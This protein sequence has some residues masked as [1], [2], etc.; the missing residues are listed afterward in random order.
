VPPAKAEIHVP[1]CTLAGSHRRLPQLTQLLPEA[2]VSAVLERR[3]RAGVGWFA[4]G[5]STLLACF[6]AFW[7]SN[8]AFHEGWFSPSFW[9]NVA[10]TLV[11]YMAPMLV[12]VIPTA[13]CTKWRAVGVVFYLG[14]AGFLFFFFHHSVRTAIP[15]VFLAICFAYGTPRPRRLAFGLAVGLPLL[16]AIVCGAGP[17][18]RVAHR[19]N[20]GNYGMRRI[21]GNGV[22]LTWAPQGPG[23]PNS[24]AKNW[25]E[26]KRACSCLQQDGKTV[27]D[28][29]LDIWRLP[30]AEEIVR[31]LVRHGENAG[32]RPDPAAPMKASY[33]IQPDKETPLWNPHSMTIYWWSGTEVDANRALRVTYNGWVNQLPKTLGL[34]YRCVLR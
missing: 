5:I 31:S 4:V 16:T 6:W 19:V 21:S 25:F 18:W 28:V 2:V 9:T 8:E 27:S 1:S 30:T 20:D 14:L 32:G 23:W 12:F 13:L 15:M 33:R 22:E 10:L 26:A 3:L 29:P 11:Q 24:A 34:G 17:A 7:G